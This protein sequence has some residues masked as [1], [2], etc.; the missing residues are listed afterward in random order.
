MY[1]LKWCTCVYI[2][3]YSYAAQSKHIW[4]DYSDEDILTIRKTYYAMC[5]E[6]DYLMGIYI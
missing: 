6:T 5:A 3:P 1:E 2:Y 4:M